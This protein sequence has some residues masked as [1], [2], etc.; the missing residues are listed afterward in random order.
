MIKDQIGT[1][2]EVWD[3]D[4]EEYFGVGTIIDYER[5][6]VLGETI[7]ID[8]DT[9]IIKLPDNTTIRGFECSY[10]VIQRRR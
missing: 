1:K 8:K 5:V 3:E 9:P 6:T 4:E 10:D 2:V 7:L